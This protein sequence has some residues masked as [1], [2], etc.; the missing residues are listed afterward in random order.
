[1]LSVVGVGGVIGLDVMSGVFRVSVV[2]EV[3]GLVGVNGMEL[4]EWG[5]QN[6]YGELN[7][8]IGGSRG[9]VREGTVLGG[10]SRGS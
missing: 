2:V 6:T 7:G 9:L 3:S 5:W 4:V 8:R 1:M 10:G